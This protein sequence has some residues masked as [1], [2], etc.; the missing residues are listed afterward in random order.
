MS[1]IRLV[2]AVIFLL[3]AVL[4]QVMVPAMFL[5]QLKVAA[6][7]YGH[8]MVLGP[9]AVIFAGRRRS[10]VDSVSVGLAVLAAV[11]FMSSAVRAMLFA[12]T[13]SGKMN[14]VFPALAGAP[15]GTPFSLMRV[16]FGKRPVP[17]D[18]QTFDFADHEGAP[19][20]LDFYPAQGRQSAPCVVMLHGGGWEQGERSEFATM[21]HHL[22][23]LGYAVAA[24]DYR[25]APRWTWPAP[26]ED[27]LAAL[28]FLKARASELGID[29][30]RFVLFGRSAGGQI[31]ESVAATGDHPEVVGCI[32]FYA[33]AD[34][35]FAFQYAKRSDILNSDKLLRQVMG[36]TPT[37]NPENYDTASGYHVANPRTP[38]TLQ[39]HGAKDELVWDRQSQRY[40]DRLR[41]LEVRNVFLRLPWATHAFDHNF[42]GPGG[43]VAAWAVERFLASVTAL[44][45][46][47]R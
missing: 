15:K 47:E 19:L 42:R 41:A 33:P 20:R 2:F 37:E 21:N 18:V 43:Q 6:T 28:G 3:V 30:Q 38:P 29:P 5:W 11:F 35:R 4:T 36:G 13:A 1:A 34:M 39:L 17:V 23:R 31:A 46:D 16:W 10:V 8:W 32:A 7:E 14:P 12:G 24:I 45:V 40:A 44:D 27:T 22:A 25:L 9:L 26:Q